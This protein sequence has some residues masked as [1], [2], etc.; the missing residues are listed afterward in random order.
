MAPLSSSAVAALEAALALKHGRFV[1]HTD[2]RA[3]LVKYWA[4]R[5]ESLTELPWDVDKDDE[6]TWEGEW[7]MMADAADIKDPSD[8]FKLIAW[9]R[10]K[11]APSSAS[12]KS[13]V[14]E[15]TLKSLEAHGVVVPAAAIVDL[16]KPALRDV[17]LLLR[18]RRWAGG[19]R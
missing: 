9:L 8:I 13:T 12:S 15:R 6:S 18:T 1:L 16:A 11:S 2:V 5:G 19:P 10:A 3:K 7:K 4:G 17:S 14:V